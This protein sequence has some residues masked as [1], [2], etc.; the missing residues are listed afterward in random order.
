MRRYF[1]D[2]RVILERHG[3]T[4]EKFVG[5]AVMAVFGIPVSHEDDALRAVRAAAEMRAAIAEHGL[6][7]RIGI[8]TGEVVVG[9]EGETLVTGDAV[10]VAARLEQAAGAGEVFIGAETHSLVRDAVRVEAVEPLVLKGKAEPVGGV[11]ACSRFSASRRGSLA[12]PRR[13]S[14]DGSASATVSGATSRTSVDD[15]SCRL[16]TLLGPAGIGKSRL[17]A[18]FLER[19]GDSADVLRGRCLSYGEG[20]TYWPLVEILIA[21]GVE[22]DSVIG[23]SPPETQLAFRRLLEARAAE[24]PQVVRRRRPA[25]GGAG[26]HRPRRARRRS[27]ARRA[28]LPPLRRAYRA[29]RRTTRL[30]RRQ[31]ERDVDP[32]RAARRRRVRG[33]DRESPRRRRNSTAS[34]RDRITAASAGNPLY[35]EEMLAMVRE[36]GGDGEIVVPPTIHALLQARIDSLDGDVRVVMERGSVEGEVFHRGAVARALARSGSRRCRVAS[37][38]ARAQGAHP[39]DRTDLPRGRGVPLSPPAHPRRRVRV[40]A[41]GDARGA[42]RAVRRL[43]LDARPGRRRRDRRVPPRAGASLPSGARSRATGALHELARRASRTPRARRSRRARPRR[44]QRPARSLLRRAVAI[45]LPAGD[46]RRHALAPDLVVALVGV[47]RPRRAPSGRS[48]RRRAGSGRRHSRPSRRALVHGRPRQAD[49]G[50]TGRS[51]SSE[52]ERARAVLEEAETTTALGHLLVERRRRGVVALPD[53]GDGARACEACA[54]HFERAGSLRA[55]PTTCV[56]DPVAARTSS[57]RRRSTRRSSAGRRDREAATAGVRSHA[58]GR[59]VVASGASSQWRATSSRRAT[60]HAGRA[61][62]VRRCRA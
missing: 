52:R 5:D 51:A 41:E 55:R 10:N 4:V 58:S 23:T 35:V 30:G 53:D 56:A 7:A 36:H 6:E 28:D 24:R 61:E 47:G 9:G 45:L 60:L 29:P 16:V 33:A 3:G 14:S 40:A 13:F 20:I 31:D 17:V 62:I 21:I 12:T 44:L 27:L 59:A 57:G 48:P 34:L 1:E 2:L 54:L 46:E 19:V 25:V 39:L 26:L 32:A 42:A 11:L 49:S 18:D 43:A 15:R 38:D 22:P 50:P 8:N 37:D